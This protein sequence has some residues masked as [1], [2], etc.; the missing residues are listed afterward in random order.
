[1]QKSSIELRLV[2]DHVRRIK[3]IYTDLP[4]TC[5]VLMLRVT[6]ALPDQFMSDTMDQKMAFA[7][8]YTHML[9]AGKDEERWTRL[10]QAVEEVNR[11]QEVCTIG[12]WCDGFDR[13]LA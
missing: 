9:A 1:M 5:K 10:V 4:P 6:G 12:K 8:I 2:N 3:A 7:R 13:K 11:T